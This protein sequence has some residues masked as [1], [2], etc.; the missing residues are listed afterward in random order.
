ML[1][2]D[3]QQASI[4]KHLIERFSCTWYC[5]SQIVQSPVHTHQAIDSEYLYQFAK[6]I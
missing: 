2:T 6:N 3:Q 5:Y 4:T 1:E